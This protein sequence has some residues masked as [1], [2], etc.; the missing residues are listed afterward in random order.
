MKVWL[1]TGCSSGLG[2][3]IARAALEAGQQVAVT[4]RKT[5]TIREFAQKYPDRALILPLDLQNRESMKSAVQRV[6]ER[7]GRIDVLVNNAGHGYRAAVEESEPEKIRE[8]FDTDFFAPAELI[9][10]VLPAMRRQ[11]SGLIVNV[12]SIGAVRGALGNGYY[13]AAKGALELLTDSLAK[14]TKHLGIEAMLVEPGAF[15][16]RFYDEALRGTDRKIADYDVIGDRYRKEQCAN[17]RNQPGDPIKGGQV[18]VET[19]LGK[20]RPFRLLL[21]S[22]AAEAAETEMEQRLKE[23]RKW[24]QVSGSTD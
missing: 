12:T 24:K 15:R 17:Q 18:I 2:R 5:E 11:K 1:I 23:I 10:M 4:A 21:G 8:L 19:I 9:Q 16:T 20:E 13:S 3:G 7:F 6:C 22:D 14:E